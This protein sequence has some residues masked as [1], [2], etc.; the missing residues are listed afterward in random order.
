M[1]NPDFTFAMWALAFKLSIEALTFNAKDKKRDKTTNHL[2]HDQSQSP[3]ITET[4]DWGALGTQGL[5]NTTKNYTTRP[6]VL[7][8][9]V[10]SD[11][12][13]AGL[14]CFSI[15]ESLRA[16][17]NQRPMT[18]NQRPRTNDASYR[19]TTQANHKGSLTKDQE[20]PRVVNHSHACFA[21]QQG[22]SIR[23]IQIGFMVRTFKLALWALTYTALTFK[24]VMWALAFK[25]A[26]GAMTSTAL[27]VRKTILSKH[28]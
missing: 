10:P 5:L 4:G 7:P 24:L 14:L 28:A 15:Y 1:T 22:W 19:P 11:I 16:Q 27:G 2:N 17:S 12:A 26:L 23:Y 3:P 8:C 21:T 13:P 18:N 9:W 6:L 25:F 20:A